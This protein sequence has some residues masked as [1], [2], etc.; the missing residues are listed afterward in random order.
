[1]GRNT[2]G[3]YT[4]GEATRIELTEL[5]KKG[6]IKKG[7]INTGSLSWTNGSS[8]NIETKYLK[9]EKYIRLFYSITFRETNEKKEF[10]YKINLIAIPSN[11]GNGE[12]L[13]FVCPVNNKLCRILYRCYQSEI[14]KS[15]TAYRARIYYSSQICSKHDKYNNRYFAIEKEIKNFKEE[16]KNSKTKSHYKGKETRTIKKNN[17]LEELLIKYDDLRFK[18]FEYL[19]YK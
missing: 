2:T 14:W 6:Y 7:C 16:C 18:L 10:D 3:A 19:L 8:I 11:L 9:D 15:R 5:L 12:V 13:Y 1:M 17:K 4:T